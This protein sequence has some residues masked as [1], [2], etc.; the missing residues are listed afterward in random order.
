MS[1]DHTFTPIAGDPLVR[2]AG[3]YETDVYR[4]ADRRFAVKIRLGRGFGRR[5]VLVDYDIGLGDR[6]H[7]VRRLYSAVRVLLFVRD[8]LLLRPK[9]GGLRERF[10]PRRRKPFSRVALPAQLCLGYQAGTW[11]GWHRRSS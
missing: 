10:P 6:H 1:H 2:F 9:R 3:G 5:V 4:T 11:Q 8:L 7:L